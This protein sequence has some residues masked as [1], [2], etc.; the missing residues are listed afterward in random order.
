VDDEAI[1]HGR[2]NPL[3]EPQV[4]DVAA[5]GAE[6]HGRI[7]PP[8]EALQRRPNQRAVA[9]EADARVVPLRLEEGDRRD[10][11]EPAAFTVPHEHSLEPLPRRGLRS[12]GQRGAHPIERCRQPIRMNRLHQVVERVDLE[13]PYGKRIVGRRKNYPGHSLEPLQDVKA[14]SARHFDVEQQQIHVVVRCACHRLVGGPR[15]P[16]HDDIGVRM[17]QPTQFVAGQPLVVHD[18][19]SHVISAGT[20]S[21]A[22]VDASRFVRVS[23]ARSW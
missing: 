22:T 10:R 16:H 2:I 5:A 23:V 21:V 13:C 18:H 14:A 7:E 15:F 20:R 1:V 19:H 12:G 17:K 9:V 6:E 11:N 8:L 4:H 3:D